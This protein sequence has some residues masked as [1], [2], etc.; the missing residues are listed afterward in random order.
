[1]TLVAAGLV[2]IAID[3]SSNGAVSKATAE[4]CLKKAISLPLC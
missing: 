4:Q 1:M 2:D 3:S